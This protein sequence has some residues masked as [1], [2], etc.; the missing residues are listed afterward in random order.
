[1]I[2]KKLFKFNIKIILCILLFSFIISCG[3][4]IPLVIKGKPLTGV[5][6]FYQDERNRILTPH[7]KVL[8]KTIETLVKHG[9]KAQNIALKTFGREFQRID[10]TKKRLKYLVDKHKNCQ[11]IL[12]ITINLF[13]IPSQGGGQKYNFNAKGIATFYNAKDETVKRDTFNVD[14]MGEIIHKAEENLADELITEIE[15]YIEDYVEYQIEE[16]GIND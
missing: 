11:F 10:R 13:R 4:S 12:M 16:K 1:M 7:R 14:G 9:F 6:I 5:S 2:F 3:D 15:D 8:N